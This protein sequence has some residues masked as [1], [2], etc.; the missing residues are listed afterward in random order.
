MMTF[1]EID[2]KILHYE[3]ELEFAVNLLKSIPQLNTKS[4]IISENKRMKI[5]FFCFATTSYIDL[6]CTYRNL[7]RSKSDWEKFYNIKIAYLLIYETINTYHKYKSDVYKT[8]TKEEQEFYRGFFDMLN[9]ELAE[10]KENYSYDDVMAKIRNKS[11]AHYDKDFLVFFSSYERL[12]E[13]KTKEII[14]D[15]FHFL[16]PLHYFTFGLLQGKI[17]QFLFINSWLS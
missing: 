15:F 16:N 11:T 10:F 3:E 2:Q 7:K 5:E 4:T 17:D 6:L 14:R 13:P 8:V 1:K 9:R 12:A